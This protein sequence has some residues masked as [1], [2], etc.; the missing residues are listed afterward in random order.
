[1]SAEGKKDCVIVFNDGRAVSYRATKMLTVQ[2]TPDLFLNV[3]D[4]DELVFFGVSKHIK[5]AMIGDFGDAEEV[6]RI[7]ENLAGLEGKRDA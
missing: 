3:Y 5:C 7:M 2:N 4:G 6:L 1:M